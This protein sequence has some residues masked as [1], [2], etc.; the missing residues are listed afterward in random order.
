[1]LDEVKN[2]LT[3]TEMITRL[4]IESDYTPSEDP[5]R[6]TEF[7][8]IK[9]FIYRINM[10]SLKKPKED[11][12]QHIHSFQTK[13]IEQAIAHCIL[14]TTSTDI[15][16]PCQLPERLVD[17]WPRHRFVITQNISSKIKWEERRINRSTQFELFD[18]IR[19]KEI[20]SYE[21]S[22]WKIDYL[23]S[24]LPSI[25]I[26]LSEE[27][28]FGFSTSDILKNNPVERFPWFLFKNKLYKNTHYIHD[29]RCVCGDPIDSTDDRDIKAEIW[30]V[31]KFYQKDEIYINDNEAF[32]NGKIKLFNKNDSIYIEEET[33]KQLK[34]LFPEARRYNGEMESGNL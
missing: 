25:L 34:L 16:I 32:C 29:Q 8:T 2:L 15:F 18:Y 31:Q 30:S 24:E 14:G 21:G 10:E 28:P 20:K 33:K 19:N 22:R 23:L 11:E 9:R 6:P 7:W 3:D 26:R 17:Y 1:M 12:W 5:D 4:I 13:T 27:L